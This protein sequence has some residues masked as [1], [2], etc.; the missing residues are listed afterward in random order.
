M[1]KSKTLIWS[2][3]SQSDLKNI[4]GYYSQFSINIANRIIDRIFDKASLLEQTGNDKHFNFKT[5]DFFVYL[6][7]KDKTIKL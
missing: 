1:E 3:S 4:Y 2:T 7:S 6:F 5:S